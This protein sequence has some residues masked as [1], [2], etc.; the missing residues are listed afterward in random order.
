MNFNETEFEILSRIIIG[1]IRDF[2]KT[3]NVHKWAEPNWYE[4]YKKT[5]GLSNGRKRNCYNC[6]DHRHI[7]PDCPSKDKGTK[8]YRCNKYGHLSTFC[9]EILPDRPRSK[10]RTNRGKYDDLT[11]RELFSLFVQ[12]FKSY[13]EDTK[14]LRLSCNK[15]CEEN[16]E[17]RANIN[18]LQDKCAEIEDNRLLV[19]HLKEE[20]GM[21]REKMTD[22]SKIE[23]ENIALR[24]KIK[25][26]KSRQTNNMRD[27][28][29]EVRLDKL[30]RTGNFGLEK[31]SNEKICTQKTKAN[32]SRKPIYTIV[33]VKPGRNVRRFDWKSDSNGTTLTLSSKSQTSTKQ[34]SCDNV[35]GPNE[36][37]ED[38]FGR[39]EPFLRLMMAGHETCIVAYGGTGSGKSHTMIGNEYEQGI[40]LKTIA[41]IM[42]NGK[43][44]FEE[45]D[46]QFSIAEIYNETVMDLM[47]KCSGPNGNDGANL[48]K[49]N[50]K[51]I[52]D[53]SRHFE[54]IKR[55]RKTAC[56]LKNPKS[57]RSHIVVK[58]FLKG[59]WRE[60]GDQFTSSITM[61]DCAGC[62]SSNDHLKG[63]KTNIR[64]SEMIQINKAY[65]GV[66]KFIESLQKE[67]VSI[68]FRN[69]KLLYILRPFLKEDT[70]ILFIATVSQESRNLDATM[71]TLRIVDLANRIKQQ[72]SRTNQM[73]SDCKVVTHSKDQVG[74]VTVNWSSSIPS[75]S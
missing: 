56:T 36:K 13:V 16:S 64:I 71:E 3:R 23:A 33:R 40:I 25:K 62:E 9:R 61:L 21:M 41:Y 5:E 60:T 29:T 73:K 44:K 6:G 53:F 58:I 52:E 15:V 74:C 2:V 67:V 72:S 50:L 68:D 47:R 7:R 37:N 24:L 45:F 38:V 49:M 26:Q 54:L 14:L 69:S 31:K 8:C 34:Y 4:A 59:K 20:I 10:P 51:S 30:H 12:K 42:T 65:Y 18:Q 28:S 70:K 48:N 66:A 1:S 19:E 11:S 17:L 57:S 27:V 43:E 22:F 63:A 32:L 46:V 75:S 35:L 39:I 55:R